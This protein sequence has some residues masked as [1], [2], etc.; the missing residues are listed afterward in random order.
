MKLITSRSPIDLLVDNY[1]EHLIDAAGLQPSTCQKWTFFV[2][3]FLKAQFKPKVSKSQL[4]Q[5]EPGA[6][7]NF[8]LQQGEHYPPGQL[9]SLA[10][11]LRSFCRFLCARGHHPRDLSAALPSI[12]GAHRQDLPSYLNRRQLRRLLESFDRRTLLGKRDY[13]I[14]LCLARLGL[15][16]GE[17]A[18]LSLDDLD[19]RNGRLRLAAPKGRRERQL[20]LPEEVGQALAAY[21]RSAP[22]KG[23]TRVVFRTRCGQR[24]MRSSWL[25]ERV[26]AGMARAGLGAP[27]KRA[28]LLRHTFATHLVQQGASLKAVADLLGHA[29]LSTT[30]VYAKVN[31]P[32]LRA[33]AQPW[34]GEVRR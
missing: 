5:L 21:L 17:V 6:L 25:S 19:W 12:S 4:R 33:V 18:G 22:Q 10:S 30:Q 24:P 2:R 26:G 28:H 15:R 13:A 31:L 11:A 20:P 27:G 16:A 32:M 3:L 34:P 9:Q 29:S 23:A 7:L 14:T 8:V 1:Q